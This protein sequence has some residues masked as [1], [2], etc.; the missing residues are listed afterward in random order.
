MRWLRGAD[1]LGHVPQV[2]PLRARFD[3]R[4]PAGRAVQ[5]AGIQT[6]VESAARYQRLKL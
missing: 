4:A 6:H 3:C 1:A 5:V 2:L